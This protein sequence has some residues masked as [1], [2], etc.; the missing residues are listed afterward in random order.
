MLG[1]CIKKGTIF[2]HL[3]H[4]A[5]T[6]STNLLNHWTIPATLWPHPV[7][8]SC[9]E[10]SECCAETGILECLPG[11]LLSK[12]QMTMCW[13]V[14]LHYRG[15][16]PISHASSS[17]AIPGKGRGN[18]SPP[19]DFPATCPSRD[20]IS[21]PKSQWLCPAELN[22]GG[23]RECC[24]DLGHLECVYLGGYCLELGQSTWPPLAGL[25]STTFNGKLF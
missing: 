18:C 25:A 9:R 13:V 19:T 8:F 20:W 15:T 2:P 24:S 16:T 7:E 1:S 23:L 21:T 22:S 3:K 5:S 10:E 11:S 6:P 12:N 17:Y 14:W 4:L